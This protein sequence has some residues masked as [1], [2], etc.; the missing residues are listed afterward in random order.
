MLT[1]LHVLTH[2]GLSWV[3]ANL[4]AVSRRDRDLIVLAGLLPDLDGVGL[5][6][7]EE[8]YLAA[9]RVVG[10]SLVGGALMIAF[11]SRMAEQGHGT[12]ILALAAFHLHLLLDIIGT[13]GPPVRYF[14]PMSGWGCSWSGHW[15]L[16]SW[17]N[18]VVMVGTLLAVLWVGG[19][20]G[21]TPVECL[22]VRADQAVV[23]ALRAIWPRRTS[24]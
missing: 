19:L 8:A 24:T 13:G 21:R 9:H 12:A 7:S 20:K 1:A 6:W 18:T 23:C 4:R 16:A 2:L 17:Q 22:S 3:V 5:L 11:L 10:H 15:E 14:W